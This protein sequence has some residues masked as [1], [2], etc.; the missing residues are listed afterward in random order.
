[1]L[2]LQPH[3]LCNHTPHL[4]IE[5]Y[6]LTVVSLSQKSETAVEQDDET[7]R[8]ATVH[9]SHATLV[10]GQWLLMHVKSLESL[11]LIFT[12]H[13]LHKSRHWL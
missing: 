12:G 10:T 2:Q 5:V 1:M 13:I 9:P 7:W 4:I 11:L 6:I 3:I 8:K